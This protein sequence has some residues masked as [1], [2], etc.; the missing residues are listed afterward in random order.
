MSVSLYGNGNTII[1]VV[2]GINYG[3]FSTANGTSNPAIITGL[4]ATIT[5]QSTTSTILVQVCL[6]QVSGSADT[7]WGAFM[8]RNGNKVYF[9]NALGSSDRGA[10]AGGIASSGAT[11]RGN[12]AFINFIDSP[13]TTAA[14]TYTVGIGGNGGA[15][16]YVNQDGRG[17]QTANNETTTPST[18]ILMEISG[19]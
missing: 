8:Y 1:Q 10:I 4:S 17:S 2:Q 6:G 14:T 5:P 11:W 7:T 19:S 9:G 13:A 18:I 16:I 12:P 15:T 3:F